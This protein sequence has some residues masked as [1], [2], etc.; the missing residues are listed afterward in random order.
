M[1]TVTLV[2]LA[3]FFCG[4]AVA[5]EADVRAHNI[6]GKDYVCFTTQD[7]HALLQLRIDYPKLELKIKTLEELVNIKE[8]EKLA[9]L[10]ANT[11]LNEQIAFFTKENVRLQERLNSADAWYKSPYLWFCVGLVVGTGAAVATVYAVK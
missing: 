2:L 7:A 4:A 5:Q 6:D 11:N 10:R 3:V 1:R 9:L 8:E